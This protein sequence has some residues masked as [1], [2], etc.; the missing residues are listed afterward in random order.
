MARRVMHL[1]YYVGT[2]GNVLS[3]TIEKYK[4][5]QTKRNSSTGFNQWSS[6]AHIDTITLDERC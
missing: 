5:Q 1:S 6:F 3:E 2:A 4:A